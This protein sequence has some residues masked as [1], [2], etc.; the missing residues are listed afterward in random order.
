[1]DRFVAFDL[2]TAN[3]ESTSICE[4]AFVK[5]DQFRE[6]GDYPTLYTLVRPAGDFG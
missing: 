1:M 2:E 6:D 5:F 4:V 3:V